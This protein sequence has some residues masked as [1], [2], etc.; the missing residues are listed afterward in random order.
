M[1]GI[2][3]LKKIIAPLIGPELRIPIKKVDPK[4]EVVKK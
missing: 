4:P 3:I 1:L 2:R